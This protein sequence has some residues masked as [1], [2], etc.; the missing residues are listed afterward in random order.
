MKTLHMIYS[1]NP[2]QKMWDTF[3]YFES[4]PKTKRHLQKVYEQFDQKNGY[5]LAFQNTSKFIYFIKQSREYF[6]SAEKSNIL[7]KPLLI[8]YGMM[9]LIK[10][11]VLTKD[12]S[13]PSNISVLRHGITTRKLK[14]N[15][16][17]FHEDEIKIQKEGLIPLFY[18]LMTQEPIEKID[19]QKYKIK[20]LLSLLP[21]L[22]DS[23]KTSFN[24]QRIYP[25]SIASKNNHEINFS[26]TKEVLTHYQ[27]NKQSLLSELNTYHKSKTSHFRAEKILIIHSSFHFYPRS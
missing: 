10:A 9:N 24:E 2:Y 6:N 23:Y 22:V 13:Y 12:P 20:E 27:G 7:V 25:F 19:G 21:E 26:L 3:V 8:Y 17:Q 14:K 16:Y 11:L 1:E 15:N 18:S 4:E 5:K